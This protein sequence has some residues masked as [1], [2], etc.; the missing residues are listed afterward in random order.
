M[1][2]IQD[3]QAPVRGE[4]IT[5]DRA[6]Y[7]QHRAVY[8]AMHDRRPA[9][10]VRCVDAADVIAAVNHA[11]ESGL[12]LA[13]RGGGHS[14]PGFG[15][16]DGG[17]VIDL[18]QMRN[19]HVDPA[20]RTA[21]VGGG[22]TW[23]D[24]DHATH[25]FG[26]ATTGGIIS[27][28]GVGGLTLGGGIGHLTRGHGLSIDNLVS[29]DVVTADG[30]QVTASEYQHE[31]LFWA[32]R[33][34]GGNFG[35]LTSLEFQLHECGIVVGGPL[36]YEAD[37]A[38]DVMEMYRQLIQDAPEQLGCFFA[39]QIAPPL[40]FVPEERVGDLFCAMVTCW[41]GPIEQAEAVLKPLRAVAEVKA[42]HVGPVPYPA[43]NSAFDALYPPGLQ[44]YW[45]A[46]F[47]TDLTDDAIAAHIEHGRKTPVVNST[48]HIYPINGAAH[49][50]GPEETAFGHRD[51]TF[52]PVIAG[53]WPDPADNEANTRWVKDYY[54]AIHP[55]S[56][57]EGGYIN[58]MSEDDSDR[59]EANYGRNY[60]RLSRV[61]RS[62]DPDNLFHLNQ[63]IVP[64]R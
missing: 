20:K 8:N 34:G 14:V 27:T 29:A 23:G 32:L 11:K 24:L 28:T 18:S 2:T 45:K 46:D 55:H 3:L 54:A 10:I 42:E 9:A 39:W 37:D 41:N 47:F 44:H 38:R 40:P 51:K 30:K 22:A 43:L 57:S 49:R 61:K 56:G 19:V 26:L 1:A 60:F 35:V 53:V 33:G 59:A 12:E 13:V 6:D 64:A 7:D 52:A 48:M 5:P 31:D 4:V 50:V 62:Y 17:L 25:A 16:S 21:R 63:N 58:F 15:T 36:L